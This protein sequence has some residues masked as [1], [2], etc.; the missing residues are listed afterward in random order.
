MQ[1]KD[2]LYED[3]IEKE[4]QLKL[5]HALQLHNADQEQEFEEFQKLH[6][7]SSM[8]EDLELKLLCALEAEK[9][10]LRKKQKSVRRRYVAKIA[11][12]VIAILGVSGALLVNNV[13]ALRYQFSSFIEEIRTDYLKLTP[14][15]SREAP[16]D[17]TLLHSVEDLHGV[18]YPEYLP[19]SFSFKVFEERADK[20]NIVF[21]N[22]EETKLLF[23]Q[24]PISDGY[25]LLWDSEADSSGEIKIKDQYSGFWLE[26]EEGVFIKWIQ[27]DYL[28]S[29]SSFAPM[30]VDELQKIAESLSY[31]K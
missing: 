4:C 23:T 10:A 31:L 11:V 25:I 19:E 2:K 14:S 9:S 17:N 30:T 20:A 3:M 13:E 7:N 27:S 22:Q 1:G 8:P 29:L 15:D 5:E 16:E 24:I 21:L 6:E 26:K 12:L 18:W 28:M